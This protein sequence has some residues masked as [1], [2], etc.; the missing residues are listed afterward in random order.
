MELM[1]QGRAADVFDLG[2]GRVLRRYREGGDVAIEAR[3]MLH[4][5]EHGYPVP[6]VFDADGAD[7]VLE[8]IDGG[9]LFEELV[10]EP[11]QY[12]RYGRLLGELH[13]RLH[14]LSAPG[15]L[16]GDG[17][18]VIH[19]DLHP[20]NVIL[21]ERGPVVI[22]WTNA[23]AGLASVDAA[24]TVI[25]TLGS[26]LGI[27]PAVAEHVEPFRGLFVDAFLET[28]DADP[29]DGLEEAVAYRLATT[30]NTPDEVRWL[31]EAAP[32]C[33]DRF[34]LEPREPQR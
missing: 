8:R 7:L 15:W 1:A 12:P 16:P 9:T 11:G 19:R 2:E 33:L 29:R 21:S 17:P 13:E 22:D 10:H 5:E 25:L 3:L 18:T 20:Q 26:D 31:R 28:C 32:R 4:L 14:R 6:H 23:C 27:E 30:H 34:Y 24:I